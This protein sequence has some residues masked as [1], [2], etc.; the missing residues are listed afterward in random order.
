MAV[1]IDPS[2]HGSDPALQRVPD[3]TLAN[4]L[5]CHPGA[6]SIAYELGL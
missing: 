1:V 3:L 2:R 6:N 4:P 5:C